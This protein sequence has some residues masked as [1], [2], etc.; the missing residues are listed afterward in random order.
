M[1]N[2]NF[3]KIINQDILS[4]YPD[5]TANG[6]NS[7]HAFT[8]YCAGNNI[9]DDAI[10]QKI[11]NSRVQLLNSHLEFNLCLEYLKNLPC[12]KSKNYNS[13]NLKHTIENDVGAPISNGILI[14]AALSLGLKIKRSRFI[15]SPNAII[16]VPASFSRGVA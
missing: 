12:K 3:Q 2:I 16:V 7:Y 1:D 10:E 9:V 8:A 11:S 6:L 5:L 15:Y 4:K 13:Y 14:A